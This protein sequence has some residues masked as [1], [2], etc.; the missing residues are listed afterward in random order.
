MENKTLWSR[1][2]GLFI[3]L[4]LGARFLRGYLK[5]RPEE[6]K[7]VTERVEPSAVI[8]GLDD[9]TIKVGEPRVFQLALKGL[10][11]NDLR[12]STSGLSLKKANTEGCSWQLSSETPGNGFIEVVGAG[13]VLIDSFPIAVVK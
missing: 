4:L 1:L 2:A 7:P 5:N 10:S 13:K 12:I 9:K 3:L 11:C 6:A 8:E